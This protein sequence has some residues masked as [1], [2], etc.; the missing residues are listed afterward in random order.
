MKKVLIV[1]AGLSGSVI[2]RQ[3][4][5]AGVACHVIE[6]SPFIGGMCHSRRDEET[7]VEVHVFGPHIFHTSNERVWAFVQRFDRF[8]PWINRV[9][10]SNS[11]GVFSMPVNLHTINQLFGKRFT[12]AEA[13]GFIDSIRDKSITAPRN[14][15]ETLLSMVGRDIYETFF[16]GYTTKQWGVSPAELPADIIKRLPLRFNYED[17]YYADCYQGFPESGYTQWIT[18]MLQHP[19]ISVELGVEYDKGMNTLYDHVFYAGPLDEYFGYGEGELGYRTVDFKAI[20]GEGDLQ[21]CGCLNFSDMSV[22]YTR[23]HEHKYFAPWEKHDKSIVLQEFSSEGN[24]HTTRYYPKRMAADM[25][26]LA[27]YMPLVEQEPGVSFVGRMGCYRYLD[28]HHC[29]QLALEYADTWLA[30][31]NGKSGSLPKMFGQIR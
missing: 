25:E 16:K 2:A 9:K 6:R 11:R 22:P 14:A 7:G 4:A 18:N 8:Y 26:M 1:G 12:P 30:W 5:E 24:R 27:R 20:R 10:A 15:E 21:G 23:S 17:N 13:R 19:L 31:K 28:M 29:V 3:L